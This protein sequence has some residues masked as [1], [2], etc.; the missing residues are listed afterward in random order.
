MHED[1]V[2]EQ[3][4]SR[5]VDTVVSL[6]CDKNK[7]FTDSLYGR[8][9]VVDV[10]REEDGVGVCAGAFLA[11]L[12]PVMSIQ[13]SGIGN[14][15][16]A[17]MSL[18]A[19]YRL[20]LV[21]LASWRG[22]EDERIEAQR[23][24]N[25]RIPGLLSVYGIGC[26]D[27][28]AA[29][30]IPKV[31]KAVERAYRENTIEVVL[32]H[33]TM[34]E[35]SDRLFSVEDYPAERSGYPVRYEGPAGQTGLTRLEAI[36]RI[37]DSV[38]DDDIVVSN[39]GVPS[40]EVYASRDRPLNFY[41]L[42]S[43]TQATP[44]G[45][46]MSLGTD[47]RVHVIDGDGSILGSSV[48]PVLSGEMPENLTVYCLDNGTFGSTGNQMNPAYSRVDMAAVAAGFG[49]RTID[50]GSG[51]DIPSAVG[52]GA[53]VRIRILPGNSRSPNIPLSAAEI[54]DRFEKAL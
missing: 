1:E 28:A 43:Y 18:T 8:F 31:G 10:T 47:R 36:G 39:I 3:L 54:R 33:P 48:L 2:M 37:M 19:C 25:P 16:N 22:L 34:W 50:A 41:M 46:G 17:M 42:G 6:P 35:G 11:G 15:L 32:I 9:R 5:G 13:S 49:L 30:D 24:F 45:Y 29:S 7:R 4:E 40:K 44:I 20:P 26:W 21:I 53:F 23:C 52:S 27:V 14:M 38:D 12:R 51:D